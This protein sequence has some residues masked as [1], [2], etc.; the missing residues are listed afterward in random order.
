MIIGG[1]AFISC[2]S[3]T[4]YCEVES[5]PSSWSPDRNKN[6]RPVV[7]GYTEQ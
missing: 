2:S 4:I 6:N 3:L 7:W 1:N 5:Q